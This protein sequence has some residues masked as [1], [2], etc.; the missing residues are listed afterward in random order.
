MNNGPSADNTP[1]SN[2]MRKEIAASV[3]KVYDWIDTQIEMLSPVCSACGKCCL[4]DEFGHKLFITSVEI[5]CLNTILDGNIPPA[6][7]GRCPFQN[8]NLCS[9]RKHRFAACR[10]FFC[11][12]DEDAMSRIYEQSLKMLKQ[13][14]L[15]YNIA[16][17]YLELTEAL[18]KFTNPNSSNLYIRRLT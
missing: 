7:A 9:I 3:R 12:L 6:A 18:R 17:Q 2:R 11:S 8:K 13:I 4:F 15:Q 10:I 14:T 1:L 5:I 16:Y